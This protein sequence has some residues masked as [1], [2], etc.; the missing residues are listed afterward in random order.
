MAFFQVPRLPELVLGA[1]D[2]ELLSRVMRASS[3]RSAFTAEELE[4]YRVMWSSPGRIGSMLDWYRAARTAPI[5]TGRVSVPTLI[6]WG[7]HDV[8]LDGRMADQSVERCD[9][10]RLVRLERASHWPHRDEPD[11]VNQLL[12]DHLKA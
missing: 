11:R 5:P 7:D 9:D 12:I 4:R 10:V 1:R 2:A 8:A 3:T 6:I